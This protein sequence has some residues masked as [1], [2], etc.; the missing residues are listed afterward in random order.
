MNCKNQILYVYV[1]PIQ[2]PL[3][4]EIRIFALIVDHT[5]YSGRIPLIL[6]MIHAGQRERQCV[7]DGHPGLKLFGNDVAM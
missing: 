2:Q 3:H 4:T 7:F 6:L 5:G 1:S